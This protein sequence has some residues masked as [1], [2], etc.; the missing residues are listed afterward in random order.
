MKPKP[1]QINNK[2]KWVTQLKTDWK[3]GWVN[4]ITQCQRWSTNGTSRETQKS[5]SLK[6]KKKPIQRTKREIKRWPKQGALTKS[7]LCVW[8]FMTKKM[9]QFS[10]W[11]RERFNSTEWR[12]LE[13]AANSTTFNRS[14]FTRWLPRCV[15]AWT[16]KLRLKVKTISQEKF[17]FFVS[18]PNLTNQI[19]AKSLCLNSTQSLTLK[20]WEPS[21]LT[22]LKNK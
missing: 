12:R 9:L 3:T 14:A 13:F 6:N 2:H 15:A 10:L 7:I 17:L 16:L 19:W 22:G 20:F 21:G 18:E 5:E 8:I 11:I 4:T 1:C